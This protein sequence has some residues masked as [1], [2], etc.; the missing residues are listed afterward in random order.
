[1]KYLH[2]INLTVKMETNA[3]QLKPQIN[4]IYKNE[5]LVAKYYLKTLF[6]KIQN[7]P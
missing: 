6:S 5:S 7:Y 1:M 3:E 4:F 2:Q